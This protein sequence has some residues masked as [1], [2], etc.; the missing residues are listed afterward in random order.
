MVIIHWLSSAYRADLS[1]V[2]SYMYQTI[3][4]NRTNLWGLDDFL[5]KETS[6]EQ[7]YNRTLTNLEHAQQIRKR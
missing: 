5:R 1:G 7:T 4:I 6:L 2:S 3:E